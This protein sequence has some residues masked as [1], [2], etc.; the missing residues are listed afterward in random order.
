MYHRHNCMSHCMFFFFFLISP[1][2]SNVKYKGP[3]T[4][5]CGTSQCTF[6]ILVW[7]IFINWL[8]LI[9]LRWVRHMQFH[10]YQLIFLSLS[11]RMLWSIISNAALRSST[12]KMQPQS[13]KKSR[14]FITQEGCFC[15]MEC[16]KSRLEFLTN[17]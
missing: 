10:Y 7:R 15:A 16:S 11:K 3:R 9:M 4:K 14:S 13:D 2:G 5:S 1:F 17:K 12:R 6:D 8:K